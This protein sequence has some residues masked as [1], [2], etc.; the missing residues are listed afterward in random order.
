ME[1]TNIEYFNNSYSSFINDILS[2][3]P[4]FKEVVTEYYGDFLVSGDSNEDKHVKR[5]M[6]KI[7]DY[8]TQI[9]QKDESIFSES[10]FLIKNVD[11]KKIW[12]SEELSESNKETIWEYLQTLFV[13]GKTI[14]SDSDKI[15]QMVENFKNL[16][17]NTGTETETSESANSEDTDMAQMLKNL[18]ERQ[19]SAEKSE[20]SESNLNEDMLKNGMI[21]KLAQELS[22]EINIDSL[23]LNMDDT[24]NVDDIFSNLISGDNPMKFMNL[25]QKVGSKIQDKVSSGGLDQEK[26]VEEATSMMGALTGGN[27][28]L[29]NLMK[30]GMGAGGGAVPPRNQQAAE[31][32]ASNP[33]TGNSTRDRLRRK[34]EAKKKSQGG[35]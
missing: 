34:L 20:S 7:N 4:E 35:N 9:V 30:M 22:E 5:F 2:T 24:E 3:F 26:L 11:F 31:A 27:P 21:G 29:D 8:N 13:L 15:K 28:L 1:K 17:E 19:Q 33:H 12:E 14:I 10:L 23:N 6:R 25:L 16:R 32:Q 18:S